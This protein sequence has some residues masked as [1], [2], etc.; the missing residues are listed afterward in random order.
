MSQ[1]ALVV[2]LWIVKKS[3]KFLKHRL[4]KLHF[5]PIMPQKKFKNYVKATLYRHYPTGFYAILMQIMVG[6]IV[7]GVN[8]QGFQ[9]MIH[10]QRP[11]GF[12]V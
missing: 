10:E 1:N 12:L 9:N 5:S 6:I 2:A 7:H 4:Y 11:Q 3:Q 8:Q